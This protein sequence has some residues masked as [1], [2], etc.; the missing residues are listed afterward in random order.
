M[1][2]AEVDGVDAAKAEEDDDAEDTTRCR[3]RR[4]N[5]DDND[6]DGDTRLFCET[7]T[8]AEREQEGA[9]ITRTGGVKCVISQFTNPNHSREGKGRG[10][11]I[12][13]RFRDPR[14]THSVLASSLSRYFCI[15]YLLNLVPA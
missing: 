15:T 3:H 2:G 10:G 8:E 12:G 4:D 5:D 14:R 6:R 13:D 7:D 1:V 11:G 9:S